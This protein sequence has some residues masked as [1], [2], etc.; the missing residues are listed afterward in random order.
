M[1]SGWPRHIMCD[2]QTVFTALLAGAHN[3]DQLNGKNLPPFRPGL[4]CNRGQLRNIMCDW[5]T[6]LYRPS[7]WRPG[8]GS[9]A[10]WHTKRQPFPT[11]QP[12]AESNWPRHIGIGKQRLAPTIWIPFF[13]LT[14]KKP[15]DF[16]NLEPKFSWLSSG[17]MI[18]PLSGLGPTGKW[19]V[20]I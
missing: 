16:G 9:P 3:M 20:T 15:A 11:G 17:P 1:V 2:W 12:E 5:Q 4:F 10:A 19:R 8:C 13:Y 18:A 14:G 6:V 7:C